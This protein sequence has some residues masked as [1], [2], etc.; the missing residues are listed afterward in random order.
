MNNY[1]YEQDEVLL[2]RCDA[3]LSSLDEC[4]YKLLVTNKY[5]VF[6]PYNSTYDGI[7][8][9]NER[10]YPLSEIKIF[11]EQPQIK[12]YN[13]TVEVYLLNEVLTLIIPDKK[14][15]KEF[16]Q[17]V[18]KQLT[19]KSAYERNAEKVEHAIGVIDKTLGIDTVQS[20]KDIFTNGIGNM[21][22]FGKH[23]KK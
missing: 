13:D 14:Q 6:I 9:Y 2:F 21:L 11:E 10:K 3:Y 4:L 18:Y 7:T 8:E 20:I 22:P 19:G 1:K 15:A 23:K 5:L 16:V 17:A 12:F